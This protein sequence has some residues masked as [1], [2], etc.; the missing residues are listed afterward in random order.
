MIA[1]HRS[2][3]RVSIGYVWEVSYP[4][5]AGIGVFAIT[6]SYGPAIFCA[7]DAGKIEL[8]NIYTAIAGLFAIITGF[9]ATFYGSI[10]SI[11]DTR[12]RRVSK[13]KVFNRFILYIK[14]ATIS[15]FLIAI[16]SIPYIVFAPTA[17]GTWTARIAVALWCGVCAYGLATFIRVAGMLFFIFEHSPPEDDAAI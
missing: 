9:L 15:G 14:V 6:I 17:L 13:T 4:I 8:S 16:I 11:A 3:G 2:I 7:I 10:Q 12:L 1:M 5:A